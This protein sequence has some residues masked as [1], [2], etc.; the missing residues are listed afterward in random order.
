L[1]ANIGAKPVNVYAYQWCQ[2]TIVA[3]LIH[4]AVDGCL[5]QTVVSH[6]HETQHYR[7]CFH[8]NICKYVIEKVA[9]EAVPSDVEQEGLVN[10]GDFQ[11][12]YEN[13]EILARKKCLVEIVYVL[14]SE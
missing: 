3:Y 10:G 4:L 11:I 9:I 14:E 12:V 1:R 13:Q 7:Q 6:Y 2:C 8:G 5:R